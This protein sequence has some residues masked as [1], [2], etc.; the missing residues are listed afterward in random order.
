L[1]LVLDAN[2]YIFGLGLF[3]KASCESLLKFL[4]DNFSSHSICICRTIVE[5]VRANLTLKEFHN[6][7][8]LI[9]I[10]TAIDEDFLI[11][12]E[13]GAKYETKGLKD[14]D[15]LI[16]AFTEWVGADALITENRHFLTHRGDLPFKV[17]T[18]EEYLDLI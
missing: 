12:F 6:F 8:K 15:A 1:Q 18:A 16:A 11:P 4:I 14:A 13:L 3:R 7:V 9:N 5:E 10:F 2:E 17:L